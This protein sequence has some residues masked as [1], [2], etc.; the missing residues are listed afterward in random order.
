MEHGENDGDKTTLLK[1]QENPPVADVNH[2]TESR[3][4]GVS[5]SSLQ[6]DKVEDGASQ[7]TMSTTQIQ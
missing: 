2:G 7:E 1:G 4:Q 5:D 3:Q 6:P